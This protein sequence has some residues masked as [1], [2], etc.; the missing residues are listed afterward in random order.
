V[1]LSGRSIDVF[2]PKV[3]RSTTGSLFHLP[4][5]V[6]DELATVVNLAQQA[7]AQ[8]LAADISGD[9]LTAARAEGMLKHPTVW[10][11]GNEARGLSDED[12]ALA[13]RVLR[14]PIFGQAESMN[15]ATAASVCL[16]ETAFEQ[17][18]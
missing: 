5:A 10:V 13:T 14:V 2:N 16:F 9:D 17:R 18:S 11:F 4:I 12:L 1:V 6:T 8:T 3:V 7:G 15:L